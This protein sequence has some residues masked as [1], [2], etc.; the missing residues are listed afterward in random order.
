MLQYV[1]SEEIRDRI[2]K[3]QKK[4]QKLNIDAVLLTQNVGIYYF[5]GTMQNGLMVVP[6][7]GLPVFYVKK[8]LARARQETDLLTEEMGRFRDLG[9]R[10]RSRFGKIEKVG[11][12]LD[13]LPY[14]LAKRYQKLFPSAECIDISW[15][16]RMIRAVKSRY[17]L[18]Q[19]Q[20]AAHLVDEV[21]QQI[22]EWLTEK[23]SELEL[24][25][26][27]E[28]FFR[29]RGSQNIYRMR[30][31]N[32]EL[33]LGMVVSG[34]AAA[35]PTYFDGPA[36]GLGVSTASP[37]GSGYKLLRRNEPILVDIGTI[38]EG[39]LVD[40]TRM[41][42]IG[43]LS[44]KHK[45]IYQFSRE[46]LREVEKMGTPGTPWQDLYLR[47]LEMVKETK[48]EPYFMGYQKDQAKFLGHGV[49]LELDEVPILAKGFEQP[50][51]KG[52]VIAI[53]PKFTFPGEGVI[54]LENTYVVT[55]EGLKPISI[56]N[57]EVIQ[58]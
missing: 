15:E 12:E 10:I 53:E 30:G 11:M 14:L 20:K 26:K 57:E 3:L 41:A 6:Q 27:I 47:A 19:I 49:G 13:V 51:E 56:S 35:S 17:E 8:S 45:N 31:Y 4:L 34:E 42:V 29:I 50:L 33:A 43:E 55:E 37:Q 2:Q 46:I 18:E 58:V 32:Q 36:G 24:A 22:P 28:Y 39:Y 21:I 52:M 23:T 1:P 40:Q 54:G 25:A 9:D 48:L 44:L 7:E 38:V 16:I 5:S